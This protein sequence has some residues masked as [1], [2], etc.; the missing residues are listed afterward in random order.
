MMN[1]S[2][3]DY[4]VNARTLPSVQPVMIERPSG[5]NSMQLAVTEDGASFSTLIVK[6]SFWSDT[7]NMKITLSHRQ[8]NTELRPTGKTIFFIF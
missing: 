3:P 7:L 1:I 2:L 6:S 8:A 4:G 5:M